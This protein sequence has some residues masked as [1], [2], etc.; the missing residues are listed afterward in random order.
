M[1]Y[2]MNNLLTDK[3]FRVRLKDSTMTTYSL[4]EVYSAMMVDSV[5]TFSAIQPHQR[6]AWHAFLAQLAVIAIHQSGEQNP[7]KS[8]DDW[9]RLLQALT[10]NFPGDEPWKLIVE[11]SLLP[12][13]LQC[14]IPDGLDKCGKKITPDDLDILVKSK[15]HDVKQTILLNSSLE[16]WVFALVSLQTMA[17]FFGSGNYGIARMNGGFSARPC[18]GLAPSDGGIGAHLRFD[19]CRMLNYREQLLDNYQPYYKKQNGFALIWLEPWDGVDQFDLRQLDPYF[20]EICRRVRLTNEKG[21]IVALT[22][23]SKN[24]RIAAKES[25]GNVG[26]FWT[27]VDI[28]KSQALSVSSSGFTYKRLVNLVFEKNSYHLPQAM[29]VNSDEQKRWRLVARSVAGG[30]GKTDGYHERE[31]L[32]FANTTV[33]AL[34]KPKHRDRLAEIAQA[35]LA[36]I[37]EVTRALV[38][39]IS[40]AASGGKDYSETSKSDRMCATPFGR[41]LDA[42]AETQYFSVL[43]QRFSTDD[44]KLVAEYRSTFVRLLIKAA[45]NLLHEAIESVPCASIRRHRSRAKAT[46]AFW[47]RL[48]RSNSVFS[49]QP[50]IFEFTEKRDAER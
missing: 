47:S 11:N 23:S 42:V 38:L 10:R 32:V 25:K 28:R 16:D 45:L 18:L 50:E 37:S 6:H 27:P 34:F 12:A 36:E 46:S 29:Y 49:D 2:I 24:Q 39:G 17:G 35:Q 20:I 30:Q 44:T 33:S 15:N 48:R 7:P 40:I 14:P 26:D 9:L 5:Y 22:K 31:D 43:E 3:I 8:Q 19:I 4:P 21:S 41:R 1:N 13:F